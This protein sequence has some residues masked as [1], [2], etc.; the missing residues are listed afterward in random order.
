MRA[1]TLNRA[2]L[3]M[4]FPIYKGGWATYAKDERIVI[5]LVY[6]GGYGGGGGGVTNA[7]RRW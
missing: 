2:C 5:S 7:K 4:K 1:D 3:R 6:S